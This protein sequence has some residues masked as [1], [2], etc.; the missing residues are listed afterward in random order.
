[1]DV[2]AEKFVMNRFPTKIA[3]EI[4]GSKNCMGDVHTWV[5]SRVA[6]VAT[7]VAGV[8]L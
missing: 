4:P 3:G 1:M 5:N 8:F 7:L 2:V 6:M